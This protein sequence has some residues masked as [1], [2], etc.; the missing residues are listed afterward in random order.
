V[1]IIIETETPDERAMF[2]VL[3]DDKL[4]GEGLTAAQSQLVAAEVIE[5]LVLPRKKPRSALRLVSG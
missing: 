2:R 5:R 4:I 1:K 3:V